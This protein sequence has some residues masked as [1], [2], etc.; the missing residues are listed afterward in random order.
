MKKQVLLAS[1][2]KS[3]SL[4]KDIISKMDMQTIDNIVSNKKIKSNEGLPFSTIPTSI[5]VYNAG[6]T[7]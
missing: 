6:A 5:S 2:E 1:K 7:N 4:D 3:L